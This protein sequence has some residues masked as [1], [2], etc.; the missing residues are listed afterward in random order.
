MGSSCLSAPLRRPAAFG[1]HSFRR[2]A[3]ENTASAVPDLVP[4]RICLSETP[5]HLSGKSQAVLLSC[6]PISRMSISHSSFA[7]VASRTCATS[8]ASESTAETVPPL[9]RTCPRSNKCSASGQC[10]CIST[11]KSGTRHGTVIVRRAFSQRWY[12]V[13]AYQNITPFGRENLFSP[14][15][16]TLTYLTTLGN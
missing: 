9:F 2:L 11:F 8:R 15:V 13:Y 6:V 16:N 10:T 7:A 1:S 5:S 4:S 3:L 14:Y 12:F